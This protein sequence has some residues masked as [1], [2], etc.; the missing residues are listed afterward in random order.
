METILFLL[1]LPCAALG[2]GWTR[3]FNVDHPTGHGDYERLE[4]VR[5]Y[6]P[7]EVCDSPTEVDARTILGIPAYKTGERF[8]ANPGNGFWCLNREQ[9]GN[10][11]CSDYT[12][13]FWCRDLPR[14]KVKTTTT[15]E[16]SAWSECG[17]RSG[18]CGAKKLQTRQRKQCFQSEVKCS[19]PVVQAR[20]CGRVKCSPIDGGWTDWGEWSTCTAKCGGGVEERRRTCTQPAPRHGGKQCDGASSQQRACADWK[21]PDCSRQ[22]T[23]GTLSVDCDFCECPGHVMKGRVTDPNKRPVEKAKVYLA[24]KPYEPVTVTDDKGRF[25]IE[26]VCSNGEEVLIKKDKYVPLRVRAQTMRPTTSEV[27]AVLFPSGKPT[28]MRHP[29]NKARFVGDSVTFCCDAKGDPPPTKYEWF[30]DGKLMDKSKSN[31]TTL[32]LPDVTSRDAGVYRCRATS[33]SGSVFSG[34]ATLTVREKSEGACNPTPGDHFIKLPDDCYQEETGGYYANVG[35]C[36]AEPCRGEASSAG[37][38]EEVEYCCGTIMFEQKTLFCKDYQLPIRVAKTCGC[39][40]CVRPKITIRGRAIAGDDGEPLRFGLIF[41]GKERVAFTGFHGTFS[42]DIPSDTDRLA[43]TFVDRSGKFIDSTKILPFKKKGGAIFHVVRLQRKAPPIEINSDEEVT[44]ELSDVKDREPVAELDIP[45]ERFFTSDG[46]KYRGKVKASITFLDPRNTSNFQQ[47]Q[48]DLNFIDSEGENFPL[49]TFGMFDMDFRDEQNSKL[50]VGGKVDF[51][52]DPS[53]FNLHSDTN[54]ED[55]KLWSMNP[56]TGLWEEEVGFKPQTVKRRKR[57]S[58]VLLVGNTEMRENRLLNFDMP[59][60]RRCW[61]KVR[62]FN[63]ENFE[64]MGQVEGVTVTLINL[65]PKEGYSAPPPSWGRFESAVTGPNGACVFAFCDDQRAD[66]YTGQIIAEIDEEILAA[67]PSNPA[68][69]DMIGITRDVLTHLDYKRSDHDDPKAKPN[70]IFTNLPKPGPNAVWYGQGPLYPWD[71]KETCENAKYEDNHFR[72]YR[73]EG[74]QYEYNSVYFDQSDLMSW[75][76]DHMSWWPNPLEFRACYIKVKI[77]SEDRVTVRTISSGGTHPVTRGKVYGLRDDQSTGYGNVS[78]TCI[79]F[80]CAGMLYDQDQEDKTFVEVVPQGNCRRIRIK[81][82]L[83]EYLRLH[84][85]VHEQKSDRR[86]AFYAPL[87]QLGHNYGIYTVTAPDP[88]VAKNTAVG[89]CFKGSSDMTANV[90]SPRAGVAVVFMCNS[91]TYQS[92]TA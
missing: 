3:W 6:H 4:A 20:I 70:A 16:W 61:A 34:K 73:T 2:Q 86:F 1:L 92:T 46:R 82:E 55:I 90:M 85:P 76:P 15:P 29:Q 91:D 19:G 84:P 38:K 67:A 81:D 37:C 8:H 43:V 26:D 45:P 32:Q 9:R 35:K 56:E 88:S 39:R 54:L 12:V 14:K 74:M 13:R 24:E 11:T 41:K 27:R 57:E 30:K 65:D 33:E 21:C 10:E 28:I 42:F 5:Y 87:D 18:R 79:E 17:A 89:R 60:K 63:D 53:Q 68:D 62:A 31:Y 77:M 49:R 71:D 7:G 72:F 58:R 47:A 75:T 36:E 22:C 51:F 78:A 59:T 64:K 66:A 52:L 25:Q 40:Y 69:A 80:K 50:Q 83:D 48:S 23:M 44:I